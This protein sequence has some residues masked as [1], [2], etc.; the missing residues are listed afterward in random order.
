M[1]SSPTRRAVSQR[2]ARASLSEP[3][4]IGPGRC[5]LRRAPTRARARKIAPSMRRSPPLLQLAGVARLEERLPV[6]GMAR[7]DL[8]AALELGVELRSEQDRDVRDPQPH[9]ED[10]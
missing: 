1:R 4:K 9:E 2:A 5:A 6:G 3:I 10:D 8:A 7:L